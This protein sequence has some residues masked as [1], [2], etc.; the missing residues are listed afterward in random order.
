MDQQESLRA[1]VAKF[2]GNSVEIFV[3]RP[4]EDTAKFGRD[5]Q[6]ALT[7]AGLHAGLAIV[8]GMYAPPSNCLDHPGVWFIVGANRME[9]A[10]ILAIALGR[11]GV[12][13]GAVP[14]CPAGKADEFTV[15]I[16]RP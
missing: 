16:S 12:V 4:T 8:T 11:A 10:K 9:E 3:N 1:S 2:A 13:Q 7:Q 5:L 6:A 15:V 14:G